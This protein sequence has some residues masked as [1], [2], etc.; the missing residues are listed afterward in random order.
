MRDISVINDLSE[1]NNKSVLFITTKNLDYIRNTQEISLIKDATSRLTVIGSGAK[2]YP[3]RLLK[4]W[5]SLLF[6]SFRRYDAIFVGFAPQLIL[7]IWG[8]RMRRAGCEIWEDFFISLYDT[9]CYDRRRFKPDS[10]VGR[11]LKRL[12]R[13]T[14]DYGSQVICDTRADAEYFHREFEED[15]SDP[16]CGTKD[17]PGRF[18]V[19]YLQADTSVYYPRYADRGE[20]LERLFP[21]EFTGFK[22][23]DCHGQDTGIAGKIAGDIRIILYF[24]TVL[25]L[26][27]ADIVYE[28]MQKLATDGNELCI[29][30]GPL[31]KADTNDAVD[32]T[33]QTP[34]ILHRDWLSQ[35]ELAQL[36]DISDIC[37]AGH[38][39]ADIDKA[40]R[41][42]PGKAYIYEAMGKTMILG[43]NPANREYFLPSDKH[44]FV[45]MGSTSAI[46]NSI[47]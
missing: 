14:V 38:F 23:N 28:A 9:F 20:V 45:E 39:S 5:S 42:I 12:D 16:G 33:R 19:L 40:R 8:R 26:Q 24:G 22:K 44:I 32:I 43:D 31:G 25:P 35:D 18:T 21:E 17:S 15:A 27:G 30:I 10:V 34:H 46:I 7:P 4:V 29:F 47:I 3:I 2:S 1:L 11:A 41:T 13:C 37:L 36:I 6:M